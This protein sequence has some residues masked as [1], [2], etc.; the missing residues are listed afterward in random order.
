MSAERGRV[1]DRRIAA[2]VAAFLLTVL[3]AGCGSGSSGG[4]QTARLEHACS[5]GWLYGART[6][7]GLRAAAVAHVSGNG[8]V[9]REIVEKLGEPAGEASAAWT[10]A[11]EAARS[12]GREEISRL[13]A[14]AAAGYGEVE[15]DL[16]PEASGFESARKAITEAER[17]TAQLAAAARSAGLA[18]C[19]KGSGG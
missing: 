19:A 8:E 15:P 4:N 3:A 9:P 2:S 5:R 18:A 10:T 11:A 17:A 6:H 1:P 14:A 13:T 16:S 12:T 7:A